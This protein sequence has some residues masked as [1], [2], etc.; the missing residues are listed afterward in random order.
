MLEVKNVDIAYGSAL[1]VSNASLSVGEKETV[2]VVG[3]NGAGKTTLLRT[4]AGFIK[5]V[6]GTITFDGVNITKLPPHQIAHLGIRY[7]MQEKRVFSDLTV[8]EN[9]ELAAYATGDWSGIERVLEF[10]PRLKKLL[11]NKARCLSGGERQ[12]LLLARALIGESK[13]LL[14]DEPTEGLAPAFIEFIQGVLENFKTKT[15]MI[16]VEQNLPLASRL[17]DKVYVM[18]EGKIQHEE[19][20]KNMIKN[21]KFK[22]YL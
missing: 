12:M 21:I 22:E 15:S 7:V 1:A 11:G 14:V 6:R 20:D 16:I 13:L 18:K 10:F 3:R 4:I 8:R 17:A 9:L 19:K 2:V 5:P